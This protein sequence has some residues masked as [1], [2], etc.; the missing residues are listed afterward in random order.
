[1][2]IIIIIMI[3]I[4]MINLY[5]NPD[6]VWKKQINSPNIRIYWLLKVGS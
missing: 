5:R 4:L 3:I 1:M 6:P 2:I